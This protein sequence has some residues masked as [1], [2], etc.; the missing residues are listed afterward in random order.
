V[1]LTHVISFQTQWDVLVDLP[2]EPV[3]GA[4]DASSASP[5]RAANASGA[6]GAASSRSPS[7]SSSESC[8]TRIL[9]LHDS[10]QQCVIAAMVFIGAK[11][12]CMFLFLLSHVR[13]RV[14]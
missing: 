13:R 9:S 11:S 10:E 8:I 2:V 5:C 7:N 12:E 1:I 14:A 6:T 4:D 3:P